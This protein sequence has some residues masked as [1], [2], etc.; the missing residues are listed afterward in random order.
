MSTEALADAVLDALLDL[1]D[2]R[3]AFHDCDENG[4]SGVYWQDVVDARRAAA[5]STLVALKEAA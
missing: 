1:I 5:V 4:R 2:V 3:A